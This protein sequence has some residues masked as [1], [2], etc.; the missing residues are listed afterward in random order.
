[1]RAEGQRGRTPHSPIGKHTDA[2]PTKQNCQGRNIS[3]STK[4]FDEFVPGNISAAKA[5]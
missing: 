3:V 4:V 1:M 2:G 5:R